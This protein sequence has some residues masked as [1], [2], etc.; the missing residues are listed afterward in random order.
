MVVFKDAEDAK[1]A[2]ILRDHG[3]SPEKRYWHEFA[4]FNF[5]MT[6]MQAAVGVAQ[7][8]RIDELLA[9]KKVIFEAYDA[10]LANHSGVSLLPKN[11]W[12]ENS[13]W[14]YTVMLTGYADDVRDRLIT[15]LGYRGIDARPGFYPMHQM[16]P[17]SD[18]G[19]GE[20]PVSTRLSAS[21]ISLPSSFGLSNDE[22]PHIVETFVDELSKFSRQS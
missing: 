15:N 8:G 22:I 6:N 21:S 19:S 11:D 5:R 20:Y 13:Y 7:M 17:Y 4:G 9:R 12:S 2:R 18:F 16:K 14:L 10:L 3:M 1:R